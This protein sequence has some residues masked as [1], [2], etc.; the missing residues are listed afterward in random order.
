MENYLIYSMKKF[1]KFKKNAYTIDSN[2]F[3][4]EGFMKKSGKIIAGALVACL[5][6]GAGATMAACGDDGKLYV[7]TAAEL[8]STIEEAEAG[9][10]I[11]LEADIDLDA[12]LEI[13]KE[14]V[15][16]LNGKTIEAGDEIEGITMFKVVANG[17]LTITGDGVVDAATQ[18]NDYSMAVWAKDGG[19][20]IING[21]T[22]QN[23]GAK[24]VED[25]G[26]TPNN[27]ELIYANAGGKITI[28]GGV[29]SGNYQNAKWGTRY[30]LNMKDENPNTEAIEGGTIVVTGGKFYAYNPA[31]SLSE[32]PQANFVAE[33][34]V[35]T[36][37]GN[38]YV[39]TKA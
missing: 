23:V 5:A 10:V 31:A 26:T 35:S 8:V 12:A 9:S 11:A 13:D 16:D 20:V 7:S 32:N 25:N 30:T 34:Y 24:A 39:V 29:F 14:I 36:L 4:K 38:Y 6:V 1:D 3:F 33:G 15:I 17:K 21:G 22:F 28:N 2:Y 37:Q 19:E 27:N 18:A